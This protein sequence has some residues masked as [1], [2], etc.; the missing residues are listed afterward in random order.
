MLPQVSALL[1]CTGFVT[2]LGGKGAVSVHIESF[3]EAIPLRQAEGRD[4]H[5]MNAV[6]RVAVNSTIQWDL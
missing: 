3:M 4:F 6:Y 1:L 5:P 2:G